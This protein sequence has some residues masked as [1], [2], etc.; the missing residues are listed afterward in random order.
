[1]TGQRPPDPRSRNRDLGFDELIAI[2]VAFSAI[3][4]ILGWSLTRSGD[5]WGVA[6]FNLLP[7]AAE[8]EQ[9]G[10]VS[11]GLQETESLP[12]T[13]V[14]SPIFSLPLAGD[15]Q[16]QADPNIVE[17]LP[18]RTRTRRPVIT[19]VIPPAA[20]AIVVAPSPEA[21]A[22][23]FPDVPD[24]YWAAPFIID[25]SRR[26]VVSGFEDGTFQPDQPVTRAQYASLIQEILP[27]TQRQAPMAFSDVPADYWAN[28]AIDAAVQAGFLRGYPEGDFQPEQPISRAQVLASLVNG[29]QL[30]PRTVAELNTFFQDS[31]QI[32]AWSTE[33]VATATRSG[34]VVNYPEPTVLNPTQPATRAE[35]A[36][37]IYQALE[38][39]GQV[40]PIPSNYVVQP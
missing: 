1:M 12:P 15:V 6:D 28:Q 22:V 38:A 11:P 29:M 7:D 27:S 9:D 2:F 36:A 16:R 10:V 17:P 3:G 34:L 26:G 8:T 32:P 31:E 24:G 4:A 23:T 14:E 5:R 35:V 40:E 39:A 37:M 33:A 19:E 21:E 18:P 13:P 25:L 30:P 20:T